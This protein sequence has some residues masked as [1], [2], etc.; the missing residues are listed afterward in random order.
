M[1]SILSKVIETVQNSEISFSKYITAN[2][3]GS[4]GG[5]QSGFHIHKNSWNL[6]FD[7]EGQK[8]TNKDKFI[9]IKWQNDF[10]TTSRFIYY[11]VGTRNEYRLTRF[12]K[13]FPFLNDD[14]IGDVLVICKKDNEYYEAF[15]LSHDEDIDSFLNNL[16]I[17]STDING[18]IPKQNELSS[19]DKI[20]NC[21]WA[22]INTL[23]SD[24]PSTY[25]L[26]LNSRNCHIN[27]FATTKTIIQNNPDREL[28]NWLSTEFNLFKVI[29]NNRY[30]NILKNH[31]SSVED[32][33]TTAN[34]IL[35]RRK[36]R[37]GK[38]LEHHLSEI[39]NNFE[40]K[41][42]TQSV[43]ED[44]KKPDFLFPDL[45]SYHNPHFDNNKLIT[46]ASKTTCKDRWRQILNEADKIKTKHLFTLQQGI[47]KNQ[48]Q[49]MYKYNVCL[50]VPKPYLTSFPIEFRDKIMS[51]ENFVNHVKRTQI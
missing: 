18:I 10:E 43:T 5:H 39:F 51:L 14:N 40:I 24:F 16:N 47:S 26:A 3:T 46:L 42:S 36:S 7:E 41:Y 23:Q 17:S 44:N 38:S 27:S 30:E 11:G 22:Y 25:E 2:D 12:G 33:I 6:F 34:T 35:N 19:E 28:L 1:E 49:E 15:V 20:L 8:G 37:A 31:F 29:E 13:G 32:L 4:T 9:T 21:F 50:V 45:D 48:L